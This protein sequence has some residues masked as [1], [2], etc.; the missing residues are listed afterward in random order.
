MLLVFRLLLLLL[1]L[2][3]ESSPRVE[4]LAKPSS[5]K[6]SLV[7]LEKFKFI[8]WLVDVSESE[9]CFVFELKPESALELSVDDDSELFSFKLAIIACRVALLGRCAA[10]AADAAF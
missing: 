3:L 9:F 7:L 1:T 6:N 5:S 2:I 10:A 4:S 8:D